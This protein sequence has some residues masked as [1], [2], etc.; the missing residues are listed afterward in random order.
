[1]IKG[2]VHFKNKS[3]LVSSWETDLPAPKEVCGRVFGLKYMPGM[4]SI[5]LSLSFLSTSG[6]Y[7]CLKVLYILMIKH[8]LNEQIWGVLVF[9][10]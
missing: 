5:L 8:F 1:M 7:S 4:S 9:G 3:S 10:N 2:K 6:R